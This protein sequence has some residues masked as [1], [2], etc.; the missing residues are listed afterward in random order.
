[1]AL[2]G[3]WETQEERKSALP[4][5]PVLSLHARVASVR[6]LNPGEHAGYGLAFEAVRPTVI[7]TISIGYGDGLPRDVYKRQLFLSRQIA[8]GFSHIGPEGFPGIGV[9]HKVKRTCLSRHIIMA[10]EVIFKMCIRD[11]TRHVYGR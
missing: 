11:S 8:E 4:L 2:F 9:F 7:A 1:M 6:T 5:R 3:V 10:D